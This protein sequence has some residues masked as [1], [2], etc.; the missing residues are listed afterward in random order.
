MVFVGGSRGLRT[1]DPVVFEKTMNMD[2]IFNASS[3]LQPIESSY[4]MLKELIERYHP[5]Y[6]VIAL[7]WDELFDTNST[8]AKVI[9]LD[10]LTGKNKLKYLLNEFSIDEL[11]LVID[12]DIDSK[13]TPNNILFSTTLFIND[14]DF[15]PIF[16]FIIYIFIFNKNKIIK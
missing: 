1:F 12:L 6:A 14:D 2:C 11:I 16:Y 8:L 15:P 10:R 5:R 9:V 3:G 7:S 13:S 4:Y